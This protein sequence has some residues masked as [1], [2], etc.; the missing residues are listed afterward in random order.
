MITHP[1]FTTRTVKIQQQTIAQRCAKRERRGAH[2][3]RFS[4]NRGRGQGPDKVTSFNQ[5]SKGTYR[6]WPTFW[7]P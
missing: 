6:V 4:A 7:I 3:W 2:L 5:D 1:N